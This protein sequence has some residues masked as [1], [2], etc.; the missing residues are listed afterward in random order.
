MQ[1]GHASF[2]A[3]AALMFLTGIG[4][5]LMATL[6]GGL[7]RQLASPA[8]A[9]LILYVVGLVLSLGVVLVAGGFPA[10]QKYQSLP[11]L[12]TPPPFMKNQPDYKTLMKQLASN[13]RGFDIW[14]PDANITF[15]SYSDA[16][17]KAVQNHTSFLDALKTVQTSTVGDMKKTGYEVK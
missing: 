2:L 12:E 3:I 8:M 10:A 9:T 7:G 16:F 11:A 17:G 6:N 4:I 14:G 1:H 15:N 13:V 5:P